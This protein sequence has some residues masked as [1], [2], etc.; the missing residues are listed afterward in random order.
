MTS[1]SKAPT[2]VSIDTG[3]GIK[4]TAL[5][6]VAE[7][8]NTGEYFAPAAA[9][10]LHKIASGIDATKRY[11]L[12]VPSNDEQVETLRSMR[13]LA[14]GQIKGNRT[15][16]VFDATRENIQALQDNQIIGKS[17][18][19]S[20]TQDLTTATEMYKK[21]AAHLEKTSNY[22]KMI[23]DTDGQIAEDSYDK[24]GR[25]YYDLV[26]T[27]LKDYIQAR[28]EA[29]KETPEGDIQQAVKEAR[30]A[31]LT[32]MK[33]HIVEQLDTDID[34]AIAAVQGAWATRADAAKP[35]SRARA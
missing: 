7:V 21:V 31:L 30:D 16:V 5:T 26:N 33:P 27:Q 6:T 32:T 4:N 12:C 19:D 13:P 14:E 22:Y 23:H 25:W 24:G 1:Q 18:A 34:A 11:L 17:V 8:L 35:S 9:A 15:F 28:I 29:R 20:L 2:H 10:L 3:T